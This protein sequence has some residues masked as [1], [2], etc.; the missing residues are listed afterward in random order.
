MIISLVT[1]NSQTSIQSHTQKN[2]TLNHRLNFFQI[3]FLKLLAIKPELLIDDDLI[4]IT[5]GQ[6]KKKL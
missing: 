1:Y 2:W 3:A 6:Y 4:I 5:E